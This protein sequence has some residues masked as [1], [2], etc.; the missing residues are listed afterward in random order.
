MTDQTTG[1]DK[2]Q[3]QAAVQDKAAQATEKGKGALREQVGTRSTQ[4]GDQLTGSAD[5]LRRVAGQLREQ[6]ETA[7]SARTA[8]LAEQ[9]A[10]HTERLGRYLTESDADRLWSDLE[11]YGRRNPMVLGLAGAALGFVGARLLKA[12]AR[13]RYSGGGGRR[14]SAAG[15]SAGSW[16]APP[17][18]TTAAVDPLATQPPTATQLY[19]EPYAAAPYAAEPYAEPYAAEPYAERYAAEPYSEP[20]WPQGPGERR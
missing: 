14:S 20:Y 12:S 8:Q 2:D 10:H 3:V 1:F 7:T 6:G 13:R 5:D 17:P 19:A 15:S 9:A 18:P 16:Q 11:D 4:V